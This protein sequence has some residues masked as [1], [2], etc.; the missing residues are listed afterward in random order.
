MSRYDLGQV[1]YNDGTKCSNHTG[2]YMMIKTVHNL[3]SNKKDSNESSL[4]SWELCGIFFK[5]ENNNSYYLKGMMKGC[6]VISSSRLATKE[7]IKQLIFEEMTKP[8]SE[9]LENHPD[10]FAMM[11]NKTK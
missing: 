9:F 2:F 8:K 11:I 6:H 10:L 7:E 1:L 3:T 5:H 4:T